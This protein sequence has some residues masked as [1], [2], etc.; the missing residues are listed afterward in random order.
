MLGRLFRF[1]GTAGKICLDWPRLDAES[2]LEIWTLSRDINPDCSRALFLVL[3]T[4][5]AV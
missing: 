3:A 1:R 4:C 5:L 2:E